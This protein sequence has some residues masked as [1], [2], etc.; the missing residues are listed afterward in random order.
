VKLTILVLLLAVAALTFPLAAV[1][2]DQPVFS[3]DRLSIATGLDYA[4]YN[5]TG[6]DPALPTLQKKEWEVPLSMAYNLLA[7]AENK[8]LLSLVAGASWGCD[9]HIVKTRVGLRLILFTGGN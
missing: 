1:A 6:D 9:T 5:T 4:W 2:E 3:L 8:P 7:S